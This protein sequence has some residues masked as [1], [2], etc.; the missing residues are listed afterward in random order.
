MTAIWMGL[1]TTREAVN[2]DR[3]ALTGDRRLAADMQIWLKLNQFAPEKK[4]A[5]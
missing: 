1:T 4:Q 5:S 3:M 2:S